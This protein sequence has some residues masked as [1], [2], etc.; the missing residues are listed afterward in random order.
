MNDFNKDISSNDRI[1][2]ENV[3]LLRELEKLKL[4][5]RKIKEI[6]I[7]RKNIF[8]SISN[9]IYE[10]IKISEDGIVDIDGTV[11]IQKF[12]IYFDLAIEVKEKILIPRKITIKEYINLINKT[13]I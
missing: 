10:L 12:N 13:C 2:L 5:R 3:S 9:V 11:D 6:K 4:D 1:F 7:L 8:N